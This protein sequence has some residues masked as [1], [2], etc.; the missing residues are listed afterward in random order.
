MDEKAFV[1]VFLHTIA[2]EYRIFLENLF[3]TYFSKMMEAARCINES[4]CMSSN[5][6]TRATSNRL[7]QQI[8]AKEDADIHGS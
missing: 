5:S 3:F 6:N 4:V 7:P 8:S 2:E 1:K